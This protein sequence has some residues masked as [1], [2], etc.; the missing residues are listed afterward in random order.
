MKT[1][2]ST[3]AIILFASSASAE[4]ACPLMEGPSLPCDETYYPGTT[5]IGRQ[6]TTEQNIQLFHDD[7]PNIRVTIDQG[8]NKTITIRCVEGHGVLMD[9]DGPI[10]D[11]I[12]N[13]MMT[14]CEKSQKVSP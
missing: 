13:A 3:L 8:P 1:I 10:I 11:S 14:E 2:V 9:G 7:T 5:V 6:L 4:S 12:L